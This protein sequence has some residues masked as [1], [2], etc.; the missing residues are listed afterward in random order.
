MANKIKKKKTPCWTGYTH[1]VN[2]KP[3]FKKKGDRRVPDCKPIKKKKNTYIQKKDKG[4]TWIKKKK[5]KTSEKG[6]IDLSD[7]KEADVNKFIK[8]SF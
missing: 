6:T 2:G 1:I 8:W 3:T 7:A 4:N 5:K